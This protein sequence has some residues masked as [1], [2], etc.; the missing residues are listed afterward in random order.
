MRNLSTE[1]EP[2]EWPTSNQERELHCVQ[3][4]TD[5]A[6]VRRFDS[7]V[8]EFELRMNDEVVTVYAAPPVAHWVALDALRK[9]ELV[10]LYDDGIKILY[11]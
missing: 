9:A 4:I 1:L 5:P 6:C 7:V 3:H 2:S 11:A 10:V 8:Y